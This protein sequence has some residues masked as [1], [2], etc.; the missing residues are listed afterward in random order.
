MFFK[1][2]DQK[3]QET[4]APS[5]APVLVFT[6]VS[7]GEIALVKSMLISADI[8]IHVENELTTGYGQIIS[9][10]PAAGGMK[11]FVRPA[12]ADDALEIIK[13]LDKE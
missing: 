4:R 8:D 10:C 6:S 7:M 13:A 12:D 2:K 11:I 3:S 1:K 5:D 9:Q